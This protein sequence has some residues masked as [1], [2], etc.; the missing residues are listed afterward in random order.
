VIIPYSSVDACRHSSFMAFLAREKGFCK[1]WDM[2]QRFLFFFFISFIATGA[3]Q[4]DLNCDPW[5]TGMREA[6]GFRPSLYSFKF[7]QTRDRIEQSAGRALSPFEERVILLMSLGIPH[8]VK[9]VPLSA[10][11][12]I[13][14]SAQIVAQVKSEV[15]KF[16]S[17]GNVHEA[18][19]ALGG[20]REVATNLDILVSKL[21]DRKIERAIE[22]SPMT[23]GILSEDEYSDLQIQAYRF[24]ALAGGEAEKFAL[25]SAA[26]PEDKVKSIIA[27]SRESDTPYYDDPGRGGDSGP[28]LDP[29]RADGDHWRDSDYPDRSDDGFESDVERG[30]ESP[31]RRRRSAP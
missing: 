13:P 18:Q 1:G 7:A 17:Q 26:F 9:L 8:E 11:K 29:D 22:L 3:A 27:A 5:L 4:A 19:M 20:R 16:L 30:P 31:K 24:A 6:E 28:F 10:S 2:V 14:N 23:S 21:K 15:V 25:L 12:K